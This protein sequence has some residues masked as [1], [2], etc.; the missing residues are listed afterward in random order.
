MTGNYQLKTILHDE[1]ITIMLFPIWTKATL[2][3]QFLVAFYQRLL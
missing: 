2:L 1:G 3:Y